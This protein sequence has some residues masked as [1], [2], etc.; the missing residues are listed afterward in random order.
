[1]RKNYIAPELEVVKITLKDA[2]LSSPT[3]G[4]IPSQG[5]ELPS[6]LDELSELD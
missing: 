1:M 6:N 4:S 5:G 2:I 3:E